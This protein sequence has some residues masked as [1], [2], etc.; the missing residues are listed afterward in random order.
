MPAKT[1]WF[2]YYKPNPKANFRLFCFPYAGGGASTFQRWNLPETLELCPV[3]L[4]GHETRL[5]ERLLTRMDELSAALV[6]AL[7]PYLDIPF[8]FFGHSLG[9][10]VSYEVAQR[11]RAEADLQPWHLFVSARRAPQI[12]LR[13]EISH[14]LPNE[15][16]RSRLRHLKGTR[17]EVLENAELM[18]LM[19]PALRADFELDE[20]YQ[21][22]AGYLPLDCPVTAFGGLE[23]DEV[24]KGD[25]EAWRETTLNRFQ[26]KMFPG[27][28][29]FIHSQGE[30]L[31]TSITEALLE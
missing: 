25:L 4:P 20:T 16:F 14:Q 31:L 19:L 12:A 8:A 3:Q 26:L 22:G 15:A 17:E 21:R 23:D 30:S 24:P 13:R 9:A 1:P 28:H 29:F 2:P 5:M 10:I 27:G 7:S 6:D 11:L 18:E